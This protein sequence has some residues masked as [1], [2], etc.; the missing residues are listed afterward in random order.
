[1][2]K[3]RSAKQIIP[4]MIVGLIIGYTIVSII[5]NPE[6]TLQV[7]GTIFIG[8]PVLFIIGSMFHSSFYT[9]VIYK[10]DSNNKPKKT[11]L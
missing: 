10:K 5:R 6:S 1:M 2:K 7:L 3:K 4:S 9:G 11:W 8:L